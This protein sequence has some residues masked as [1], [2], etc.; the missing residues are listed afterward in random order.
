[1]NIMNAPLRTFLLAGLLATSSL[2]IAGPGHPGHGQDGFDPV[3]T[4]HRHLAGAVK[5][6]DLSDDQRSAVRAIFEDNR[7]D[8]RANM[9]ASHAVRKELQALL[10]ADTLDEDALAELAGREGE[11]A[12][13]R[14]LLGAGLASQVLAELDP[15][16][17]AE[18]Q[19]M[20]AEREER[21]RERFSARSDRD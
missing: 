4:V 11:L 18:L 19:A 16:Q 17:R 13:E 12:E 9:E 21:R 1:V 15:D 3:S 5:R 2:A 6:L 10:M 14:V 20:R 7:D 8:L